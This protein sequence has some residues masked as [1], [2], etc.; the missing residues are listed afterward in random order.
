MAFIFVS[1]KLPLS[2][3]TWLHRTKTTRHTN[4]FWRAEKFTAHKNHKRKKKSIGTEIIIECTSI[5]RVNC[6]ASMCNRHNQF[7]PKKIKV[8]IYRRVVVPS[9]SLFQ[10]FSLS[11]GLFA[12]QGQRWYKNRKSSL[13][14]E[15][16]G[17]QTTECLRGLLSFVFVY[18]R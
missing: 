5:Y 11:D 16:K 18:D 1:L 4:K 9:S 3:C 12:V 17:P 8:Q 2:L 14:I 7:W 13:W 6:I 15:Y 10:F